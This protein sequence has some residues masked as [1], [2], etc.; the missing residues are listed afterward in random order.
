M[1]AMREA[2]EKAKPGSGQ[3]VGMVGEAGVGK[4]RLLLEFR[5]RFTRDDLTYPEGR[6][7]H[8]GGSMPYLPILDILRLYFEIRED[9]REFI[10]GKKLEE[11]ILQLDENPAR[12]LA[13]EK[14]HRAANRKALF[15][16]NSCG[17][18]SLNHITLAVSALLRFVSSFRYVF[19]CPRN[20]AAGPIP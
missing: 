3:T 4:S 15:N 19:L 7:L 18:P 6:C 20:T 13:D 10:V 14:S 2:Y 9:D 11:K 16:V 17:L 8:H 1:A 12:A 5:S